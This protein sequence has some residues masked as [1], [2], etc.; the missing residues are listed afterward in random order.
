M[1]MM[2]RRIQFLQDLPF[3]APE[4]WLGLIKET[5]RSLRR[6]RSLSVTL[7]GSH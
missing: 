5:Y 2:W 3:V 7:A 1:N 4:R 6:G